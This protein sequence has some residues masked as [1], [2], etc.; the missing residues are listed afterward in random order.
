[1]LSHS[2]SF[3]VKIMESIKR[4]ASPEK[5]CNNSLPACV[6]LHKFTHKPVCYLPSLLLDHEYGNTFFR[7]FDNVPFSISLSALGALQ[8]M[9]VLKNNMIK[10]KKKKEKKNTKKLAPFKPRSFCWGDRKDARQNV[11]R[12]LSQFAALPARGGLDYATEG[13]PRLPKSCCR[14]QNFLYLQNFSN[15][16]ERK[17]KRKKKHDGTCGGS[18]IPRV[19]NKSLKSKLKRYMYWQPCIKSRIYLLHVFNAFLK[20]TSSWCITG[21]ITSTSGTCICKPVSKDAF[22]HLHSLIIIEN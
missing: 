19:S 18:N 6:L 14:S 13:S 4:N 7:I 17:Y 22:T 12:E 16:Y 3:M 10:K 5:Q 9:I 11:L 1:M 8:L 21:V 2:A 15:I 20:D